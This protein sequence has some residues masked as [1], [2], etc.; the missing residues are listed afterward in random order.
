LIPS[1]LILG[2]LHLTNLS[3]SY[4]FYIDI[5]IIPIVGD[6]YVTFLLK[7]DRTRS[8]LQNLILVDH[9]SLIRQKES[10]SS[11]NTSS[12]YLFG[13]VA[14]TFTT[15]VGEAEGTSGIN[16]QTVSNN[17]G[18]NPIAKRKKKNASIEIDAFQLISID[19]G[20]ES[21]VSIVLVYVNSCI[22]DLVTSYK[23]YILTEDYV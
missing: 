11:S 19:P 12:D 18:S 3:Y 15:E 7:N 8:I 9:L 16:G 5:I 14:D 4:I 22:Q 10:N 23:P 1:F 6:R 2:I 17:N 13:D 20:K 21:L